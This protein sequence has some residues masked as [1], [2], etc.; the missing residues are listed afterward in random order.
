MEHIPGFDSPWLYLSAVVIFV[1][2]ILAAAGGIGGGGLYVAI[3][4]F[5]GG[6]DARSAVPLSKGMIFAGAVISFLVNIRKK[7]P[8]SGSPVIDLDLIQAV[9]PASLA[10]TL[11]GVFVN[12]ISPNW[13]I[14]VLLF[15][16]LLFVTQQSFQS[17]FRKYKQEETRARA[18]VFHEIPLTHTL[19][20][21]G[22][23]ELQEGR[24]VDRGGGGD[25]GLHTFLQRSGSSQTGAKLGRAEEGEAEVPVQKEDDGA[26][27]HFSIGTPRS[28]FSRSRVEGG[29][30]SGEENG[31][32]QKTPQEQPNS[33][34]PLELPVIPLQE[35]TGNRTN[36]VH[37]DGRNLDSSQHEKALE[38]EKLLPGGKT[39]DHHLSSVDDSSTNGFRTALLPSSS[40]GPPASSSLS[41]D[42]ESSEGGEGD[43][44]SPPIRLAL[45][46][47]FGDSDSEEMRGLAPRPSA[48]VEPPGIVRTLQVGGFSLL[49]MASVVV[50][51]VLLN[52]AVNND[53]RGLGFAYVSAALSV[54][55]LVQLAFVMQLTRENP[56]VWNL[57]RCGTFVTVGFF[58]GVFSGLLGIGGGL[59]FSPFFLLMHIDPVI[60]VATAATCVIFTSTSTTLQFLLVGRLSVIHALFFSAFTVPASALGVKLVHWVGVRFGRPSYIVFVVAIAVGM[61]SLMTVA[62]ALSGVAANVADH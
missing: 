46:F 8:M 38:S 16:V 57:K 29:V 6:L 33:Y 59:V 54:C 40:G 55:F 50:G 49:S 44:N 43:V 13:L 51:G 4:M 18:P 56:Y 22:G 11:V 20:G 41:R 48:C 52:Q 14:I 25:S 58:G 28:S 17:A 9:V 30:A 45:P 26:A 19:G 12:G 23:I 39:R 53:Q 7:H 3:L 5:I 1:A 24:F 31:Q 32:T 61:S 60:T 42:N 2:A 27:E 62:K 37:S 47:S 36:G 15:L 35:E 34:E 10:G 21:G